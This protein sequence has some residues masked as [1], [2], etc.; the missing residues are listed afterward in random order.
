MESYLTK[1][2]LEEI[3]KRLDD[4]GKKLSAK[5]TG[6]KEKWIDNSE[7]MQLLKIS[8]RTAQSYRDNNMI[9]FSIIGNKIFYRISDCE[10]LLNMHYHKRLT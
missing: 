4:L 6:M 8:R 7:F 2:D 9:G 5:E 1:K 10:N 3:V